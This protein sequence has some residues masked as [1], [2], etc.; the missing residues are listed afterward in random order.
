MIHMEDKYIRLSLKEKRYTWKL[1]LSHLKPW[2]IQTAEL[3]V[4]KQKIKEHLLIAQEYN[5]AFCSCRLNVGGRAEIE[6]IAPKAEK[7]YPEFTFHERNLV[8]ACQNCNSSSKKGPKNVIVKF[9]R[10]YKNCEFSIVHPYF[11]NPDDHYGWVNGVKIVIILNTSK[12]INS[13]KIFSLDD[14]F[15]TEQRAMQLRRLKDKAGSPLSRDEEDAYQKAI[16][17]LP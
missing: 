11:D 15:Q 9:S 12:A 7:L 4:I 13:N 17:I 14:I 16:S 1:H 3:K 8:L 2:G 10:V 5:C 6:H